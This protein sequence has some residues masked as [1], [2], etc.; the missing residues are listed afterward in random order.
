MIN[1]IKND[2]ISKINFLAME[3]NLEGL[4]KSAFP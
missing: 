2:N 1:E 4:K 3:I